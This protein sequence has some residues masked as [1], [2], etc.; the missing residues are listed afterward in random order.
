M[1]TA[2][3]QVE[4]RDLGMAALLRE[5]A[6]ADASSVT[7]GFHDDGGP[8][9]GGTTVAYIAALHEF[10][11]LRGMDGGEAGDGAAADPEADPDGKERRKAPPKRPFLAPTFDE[12]LEEITHNAQRLV[13]GIADA[14]V[15]AEQ[16]LRLLGQD[17]EDRVKNTLRDGRAEWPPLAQSTID[18]K[19]SSKPLVDTGQMLNSVRYAIDLGGSSGG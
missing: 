1:T 4:D 16:A 9:D 12:A 7:V 17:G 13:A 14:K 6:I 3:G 11:G 5:L 8:S 18:R 2:N 19:K 10:G 15:T